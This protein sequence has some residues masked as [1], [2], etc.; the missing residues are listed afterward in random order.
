MRQ[1]AFPKAAADPRSAY[2]LLCSGRSSPAKGT[3]PTLNYFIIRGPRQDIRVLILWDGI[4]HLLTYII[5]GIGLWPL[6]RTRK[7]FPALGADRRLF[8]NA[9]AGFG[10]WHIIDS[11]LSHWVLG[12]HRIRMDVDNS[13]RICSGSPRLELSPLA[14][15]WMM[16]RGKSRWKS[17]DE[18]ASCSH[19]NCYCRWPA[20]RP[21]IKRKWPCFSG[22]ISPNSKRSPP[23]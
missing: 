13:L 21:P 1:L 2:S 23:S 10:V 12:I 22:L 9:L 5:A 7:E 6:W 15:S 19:S 20:S 17:C 3:L 4:F 14:I 8:A 16:R 18:F 11:F